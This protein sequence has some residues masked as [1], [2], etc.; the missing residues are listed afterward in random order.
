MSLWN[1]SELLISRV[2]ENDKYRNKPWSERRKEKRKRFPPNKQASNKHTP[3]KGSCTGWAWWLMPVIPALWE[4]EAGESLEPSS[5]RPA[6]ATD[7]SMSKKISRGWWCVP[8]VSVTWEAEV[9]RSSEPGKVDAAVN[10]DYATAL[11]PGDRVR[12]SQKKKKMFIL[13]KD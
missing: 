8:V 2:L 1:T 11:Q 10:R 7:E 4:A 13:L 3:L 9:G 6:W 5:F 12:L